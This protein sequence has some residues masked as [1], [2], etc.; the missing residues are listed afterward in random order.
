MYRVT[1][2]VAAVSWCCAAEA[3]PVAITGRVVDQAGEPVA[4]AELRFVLQD[5]TELVRVQTDAHGAFSWEWDGERALSGTVTARAPGLAAGAASLDV[6][7][8][9]PLLIRLAPEAKLRGAVRDGAGRPVARAR[10]VLGA[11]TPASAKADDFASVIWFYPDP[12]IPA[13]TDADGRFEMGGVPM[14]ATVHL[15]IKADGFATWVPWSVRDDFSLI[16]GTEQDYEIDLKPGGFVE[17]TVTQDGQPVAGVEVFAGAVRGSVEGDEAITDAQGRYRLAHLGEATFNIML[18]EVD[19]LVAPAH[20]S[21]IVV[22]GKTVE[23]IDFRLT[24]GGLIEGRVVDADTGAPIPKVRVASYGPSRPRSTG[25]CISVPTDEQGRYRM[26]VAAGSSWVY[27]QGGGTDYPF[28][29]DTNFDIEV[30]EGQTVKAPDLKLKRIEPIVVQVLLTDGTPAAEA[31]VTYYTDWQSPAQ[32]DAQGK[33]MIYGVRP[34][35]PMVV[36]AAD[37]N[38]TLAGVTIVEGA[39]PQETVAVTLD[40]PAGIALRL[41]DPQGEPLPGI[42]VQLALTAQAR[43]PEGLGPLEAYCHAVIAKAT[44]NGAGEV[45]FEGLPVGVTPEVFFTGKAASPPEWPEIPLLEPGAAYDLGDVLLD[46]RKM[47]IRGTVVS[48]DE[49]P[50]AGATVIA[51]VW[52]GP[53]ARTDDQGGFVLEGFTPSEEV[54][55]LAASPDRKLFGGEVVIPEWEIEP[56]IVLSPPVRVMGRLV[57]KDRQPLGGRAIMAHPPSGSMA[58]GFPILGETRTNE[59]GGF[60]LPA[61][62]AGIEYQ[63]S[64]KDPTGETWHLVS[65]FTPQPGGDTDLGVLVP[66]EP[67]QP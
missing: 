47:P 46:L 3:A 8:P 59:T 31:R 22:A 48:I 12:P 19:G 23:G 16:A 18:D 26:R 11:F 28:S 15:R 67:G 13:T 41:L 2:L 5:P 29:R 42:V 38:G 1:L 49:T 36:T 6:R 57:G 39:Q 62:V 61:L 45:R 24:P 20:E 53:R 54:L 34:G 44:S 14:G 52:K 55:V 7:G 4:G 66:A 17:G 33:C 43:N 65:R 30:A 25:T 56:A 60:V 50:V 37:V 21:V 35:R 10:I 27:Y 32:A 40:R 63:L 51:N 58:D 64:V 9:R